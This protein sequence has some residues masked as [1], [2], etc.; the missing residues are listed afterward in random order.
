[1][2]TDETRES[3]NDWKRRKGVKRR[4]QNCNERKSNASIRRKTDETRESKNDWK[5]RKGVKRSWRQNCNERKS[6]ASINR[7]SQRSERV[8]STAE[9]CTP[10]WVCVIDTAPV[11]F[12]RCDR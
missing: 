5:R 4:R 11:K 6:N 9:S 1:M 10:L 3:K 12:E 7:I 8:S 2:G